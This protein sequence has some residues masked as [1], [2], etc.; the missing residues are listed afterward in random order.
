MFSAYPECVLL[1]CDE[2]FSE[3]N[4]QDATFLCFC[5][6]L[7]MFRTV[8]LSIIRSSKLHIQLQV[9]VRPLLLPAASLARLAAGSS[10]G[11]TNTWRRM[12]SFE[13]LMMVRKNRLKLVERL[14]K[15]NK[16]WNVASCWLY[17]ANILNCTYQ[18]ILCILGV[19]ISHSV[20]YA[21]H[22]ELVFSFCRKQETFCLTFTS[23]TPA[24]GLTQHPVLYV[25]E[26]LIQW[27]N[28]AG[29]RNWPLSVV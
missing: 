1:C 28:V 11:L 26:A 19:E 25:T 14:T 2:I 3:Y 16:S 29:A 18:D 23:S 7:Y 24:P 12:G 4:Q 22:Q 10:I 21:R 27:H 13:L 20:Q 6:T 17:S 15:I 9:F 8:F 5:Q